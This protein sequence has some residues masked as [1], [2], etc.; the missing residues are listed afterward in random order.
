MERAKNNLQLFDPSSEVGN[1]EKT[2]LIHGTDKIPIYAEN[3]SKNSLS[4]RYLGQRR[5]N[6]PDEPARLLIKDNGDSVA[7]GPC[8]ILSDSNLDE[9]GG[10]LVFMHDLYDFERLLGKNKILK[11]QIP[12]S[13]LPHVM[14]RKDAIRP[15]FKEYTADLTYDLSVYKNLFDEM[16]LK[17]CR[18]TRRSTNRRSKCTY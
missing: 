17:Y 16:D 4:F 14:A 18:R 2:F 1:Q 6:Q 7:L 8:R 12:F 5:H 9:S 10:R 15:S 13:D 3:T 11:L